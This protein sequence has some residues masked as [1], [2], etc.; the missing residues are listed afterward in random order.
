MPEHAPIEI[1]AG[2]L[3][4]DQLFSV[5]HK[6]EI[7]EV[8]ELLE[9]PE[10]VIRAVGNAAMIDTVVGHTQPWT[11]GDHFRPENPQ[12]VKAERSD[13]LYELYGALEMRDAIWLPSGHYHDIL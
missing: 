4:V 12:H 13:R 1:R 5:H 10:E 8:F 11:E 9:M 3:R 7:Q 2:D 6:S